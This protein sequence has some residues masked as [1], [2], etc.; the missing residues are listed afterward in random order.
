MISI[1]IIWALLHSHGKHQIDFSQTAKARSISIPPKGLGAVIC[2]ARLLVG[3]DRAAHPGQLCRVSKQCR[4]LPDELQRATI[5][6]FAPDARPWAQKHSA[7]T[8][9]F[10]ALHPKFVQ[11]NMS[12][13]LQVWSK[14]FRSPTGGSMPGP[15][16]AQEWKDGWL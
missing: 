5:I 6:H 12:R 4:R 15:G 1:E 13:S 16:P 3:R 2:K 14:S 8:L 7:P 11:A 10:S 9:C